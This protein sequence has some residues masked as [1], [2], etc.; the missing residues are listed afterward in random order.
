MNY[1][2]RG[3]RVSRADPDRIE[4][5]ERAFLLL[6]QF[7]H[8]HPTLTVSQAAQAVGTSRPTARRI[9]LTLVGMGLAESDGTAYRL[10]P[11]VLRLGYAY[12]SSQPFWEH[13]DKPIRALADQLNE[14]CSAATLDGG[15]AVCVARAPGRRSMSEG[16][17][18]GSRIPAYATAIGRILLAG[19]NDE[20]LD[21]FFAG[22]TF[23]KFTPRTVTEPER[24]RRVITRARSDG[25]A[26]TDGEWEEGVR[27]GAVP[28]HDGRG[29]TIA[30]LSVAVNGGRVSM[31]SLRSDLVPELVDAVKQIEA[32]ITHHFPRVP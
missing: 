7:S 8:T 23:E 31:G 29:Q 14:S 24:L 3:E 6:E 2:D 11:R 18:I 32:S 12:L 16:V 9:L 27:S 19:L 30:G 10:T 28:I 1:K 22:R 13:L 20:Q 17:S 21:A 4:A 26:V 5:V 15:E 25:F